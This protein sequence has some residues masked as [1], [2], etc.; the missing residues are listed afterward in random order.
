MAGMCY[1]YDIHDDIS[2][3][4]KYNDCE[5]LTTTTTTTTTRTTTTT[6][7]QFCYQNFISSNRVHNDYDVQLHK[8]TLFLKEDFNF[9]KINEKFL[10]FWLWKISKKH[11]KNF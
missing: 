1:G 9:K 8:T 10:I 2:T 3:I 4:L 5:I 11:F 7:S 6:V